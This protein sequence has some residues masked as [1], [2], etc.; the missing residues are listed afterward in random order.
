MKFSS[1]SLEDAVEAFS[2]LPGIGKKNALRMALFLASKGREKSQS[3]AEAISNMSKNLTA[4]KR[5]HNYSDEEICAICRDPA[6]R[7][8]ILCIVESARDVMAI[9]D[10]QEFSGKYHVLGGVIS[11]IDGIGPEDIHIDSLL[12]RIEKESIEELIMAI[13]PSIEGETTTYYISQRLASTDV[14]ISVIA[15]GISFGGDLEY[16]DEIT[17][18]RSIA[19]RLPYTIDNTP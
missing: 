17:L 16:A 4:C 5:C 18:G 14:K 12:D 2:S 11:P 3:F 6:R 8:H 19:G 7:S 15:R 1:K 13:S 9:E 10:T